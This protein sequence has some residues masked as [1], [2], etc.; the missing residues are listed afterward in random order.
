MAVKLSEIDGLS[1]RLRWDLS[2]K[3]GPS[4]TEDDHPAALPLTVPKFT[5]E[6]MLR[7]TD[8][9]VRF[10]TTFKSSDALSVLLLTLTAL[11]F[12]SAYAGRYSGTLCW[13]DC[14]LLMFVRLAQDFLPGHLAHLFGL[15][16]AMRASE[17]FVKCLVLVRCAFE[18]TV[19]RD[20][21][22]EE[23][24]AERSR[25]FDRKH[26]A[27]KACFFYIL[28]YYYFSYSPLIHYKAPFEKVY[29]VL[30]GFTIRTE[31]VHESAKAHSTYLEVLCFC[32]M[33]PA[34]F[35]LYLGIPLPA[36]AHG[37]KFSNF[38]VCSISKTGVQSAWS[39]WD[40]IS[41]SDML[42]LCLGAPQQRLLCSWLR[43]WRSL[44]TLTNP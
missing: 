28:Y 22:P 11:G 33:T 35:P 34:P 27:S 23:L 24:D 6:W 4:P 8:N 16:S 7:Q 21:T 5:M 37:G 9:I 18:R 30:D 41:A 31:H 2:H 44:L 17:A 26:E 39:T 43:K 32:F 36:R 15:S 29:H 42:R 3:S 40:L 12:P 20:P 25:W 38:Y 1:R 10:Y 14:V 19:G 13:Q